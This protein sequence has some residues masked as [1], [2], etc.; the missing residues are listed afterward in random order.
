MNEGWQDDQYLIF[1]SDDEVQL[2][3][4]RY[5][6]AATLPGF[7][8][9]GLCGWDDFIVRD[10]HGSVF[11]VPTVPCVAQALAPFSLPARG[12]TLTSDERFLGKVK[13]YVKPIAFGGDPG[14]GENV[15]WVDHDQHAKLVRW[16]ND[17]YR[18]LTQG[19]GGA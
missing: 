2:V 13:W 9:L 17:Q 15:T 14:P 12:V 7:Q 18:S 3:S 8:I 10:A 6:I 5:G 4:D 1:F 11:T 19:R 16:W